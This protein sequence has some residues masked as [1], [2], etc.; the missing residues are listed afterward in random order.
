MIGGEVHCS[1]SG[2]GTFVSS[3]MNPTNLGLFL[4]FKFVENLALPHL[5][6]RQH[7]VVVRSLFSSNKFS[8]IDPNR[9]DRGV[10]NSLAVGRIG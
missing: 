1:Q 5:A 6:F 7:I 9:R 8:I 10:D 4:A 3:G 2:V